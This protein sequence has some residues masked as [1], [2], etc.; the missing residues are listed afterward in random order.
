MT[1][2][3]SPELKPGFINSKSED[4]YSPSTVAWAIAVITPPATVK[5]PATVTTIAGKDIGAAMI[6]PPTAA[7]INPMVRIFLKNPETGAAI[8]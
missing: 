4:C 5:Y 6:A 1:I 7:K 2:K 3:K 8:L